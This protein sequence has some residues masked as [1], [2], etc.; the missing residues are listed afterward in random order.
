MF[1]LKRFANL[2]FPLNLSHI[3]SVKVL[4]FFSLSLE[5]SYYNA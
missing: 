2:F 5:Y 3:Y 4:F 1:P